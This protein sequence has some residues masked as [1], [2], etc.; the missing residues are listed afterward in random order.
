MKFKVDFDLVVAMWSFARIIIIII[1]TI[2][3]DG[4]LKSKVSFELNE[5]TLDYP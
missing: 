4:S 2:T 5:S 1:I 3:T